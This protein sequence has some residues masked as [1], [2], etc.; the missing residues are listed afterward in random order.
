MVFDAA[1][2]GGDANDS[3]VDGVSRI[4][5]FE[6]VIEFDSWATDAD[7]ERVRNGVRGIPTVTGISSERC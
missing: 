4:S 6:V 2:P 5:A 3:G 1:Y 7:V